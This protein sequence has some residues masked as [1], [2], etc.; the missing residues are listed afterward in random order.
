MLTGAPPSDRA[1]LAPSPRR[2][3]WPW[4]AGS[5][6]I[7]LVVIAAT[8]VGH[9]LAAQARLGGQIAP[10]PAMPP[11]AVVAIAHTPGQIA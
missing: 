7:T 5:I 4:A 2:R 1:S 8:L 6:L 11:L 10:A 3:V 9:R